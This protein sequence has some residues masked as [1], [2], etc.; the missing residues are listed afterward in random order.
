[1][2]VGENF[3]LG[4]GREGDVARLRAL[5]AD[6]GFEVVPLSIVEHGDDEISST[7]IRRALAEGE[8]PTVADL[9]GRTYTLR[10]PVLH[11]DE[12]GRPLASPPLTIGASPDQALA[13][14]GVY[15]TRAHIGE[16]VYDGATNIGTQPTF[17]GTRRRVETHVLDFA[18][19]I[20]GQVVTIEL[21]QRLRPE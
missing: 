19:D 5:G 14:N 9:L 20:Y 4:R 21:L 7:R 15:V 10:G 18:D 2:V 6:M 17:D 12:R 13:P 16:A 3:H 8:M 1:L 11:G